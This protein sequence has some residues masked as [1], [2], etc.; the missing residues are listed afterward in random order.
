M[1]QWKK[2]RNYRRIKD[3]SGKI[4]AN[5]ITID[6]VDVEVTEEV[7]LTYSQFDRRER[8]IS[9]EVEDGK[10]L[11]LDKLMEEGVSLEALGVVLEES[12]ECAVLDQTDRQLAINQEDRLASALSDLEPHEKELIQALF[13]DRISARAYANQMG[14]RLNTIQYRRDKLL[15][16]LREKIF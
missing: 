14:V 6:G 9:E 2:E 13:F 10:L 16:K 3:K 15:K 7:F 12:A 1:K 4:I 11:S 5:V 8:Y